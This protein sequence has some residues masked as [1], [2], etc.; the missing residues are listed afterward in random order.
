[1]RL[2]H[3]MM[4]AWRLSARDEGAVTAEFAVAL[5]AVIAVL[6]LCLS[7]AAVGIAQSRLEESSRVAARAF[8]RGDNLAAVQHEVSRIDPSINLQVQTVEETSGARQVRVQ[9]E[10]AAPGVIGSVTGWRLQATA[11]SIRAPFGGIFTERPLPIIYKKFTAWIS[12]QNIGRI[13]FTFFRKVKQKRF[14]R[15]I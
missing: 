7:A 13:L 9:V 11:T 4:R 5:P 1:M 15:K 10:R 12:M 6:A 14:S 3:R 2:I 8:A